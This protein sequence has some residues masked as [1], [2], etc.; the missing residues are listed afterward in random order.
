MKP[1][2]IFIVFLRNGSAYRKLVR[3]TKYRDSLERLFE[4]FLDVANVCAALR[5]TRPGCANLQRSLWTRTGF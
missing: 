5:V 4:T 3:D 1:K 2:S